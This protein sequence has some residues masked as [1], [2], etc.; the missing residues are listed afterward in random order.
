MQAELDVKLTAG[1]LVAGYLAWKSW[2]SLAAPA[3]VS[4]ARGL[5]VFKWF[6]SPPARLVHVTTLLSKAPARFHEIDLSQ[7]HQLQWWFL[8]V[9]PKHQVPACVDDGKFMAESRDL[10]RHIFDKYNTDPANDH[11]Y[12]RDPSRRREVDEWMDWSKPLHL[13]IEAQVALRL[14]ATRGMPWRENYGIVPVLVG[15]VVE[16]PGG[17]ESLLVSKLQE[18]LDDAEARYS[19]RTI[20]GPSDL[21]LGD[22]ATMQEVCMAFECFEGTS[23]LAASSSSAWKEY[24]NLA[25]LY[26][27]FQQ[28]PEFATVHAPLLTFFARYREAR[29]LK[30]TP[31]VKAAAVLTTI[32]SFVPYA[33][34]NALLAKLYPFGPRQS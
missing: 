30:D 8:R 2:Q 28:V 4:E 24:P 7:G 23:V 15:S 12:P 5:T 21:N 18:H 17:K 14:A 32:T 13:C 11:W 26:G 6:F 1:A 10:A 16:P 25:R 20:S 3:C 34:W 22:L 19:K 31:L 9:N 29:D 27:V 33:L